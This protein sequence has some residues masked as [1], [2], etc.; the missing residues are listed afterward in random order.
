MSNLTLHRR[1]AF[2]IGIPYWVYINERP[3]GIMKGREVNINM[4]A[5]KYDLAI[6]IVFQ[7]FKW[8]FH[9]GGSRKITIDD[10]EQQHLWITDRERLWN[11]LFDIDLVL[12]IAKLFFTLP[13]PWDIIYKIL[14]NGFFAIWLIRLWIIRDRYFKII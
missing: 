4:P 8:Q 5:G 9:I 13:Y 14:S 6:R 2:K 7:L 12:W 11:I 1:Q 3:V 10:G